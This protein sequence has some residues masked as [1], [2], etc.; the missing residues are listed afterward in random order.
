MQVLES[1]SDLDLKRRKEAEFLVLGD[2][3]IAAIRGFY[4]FNERAKNILLESGVNEE[5]IVIRPDYYF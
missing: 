1:D 3:P 5:Q 2:V 4:V